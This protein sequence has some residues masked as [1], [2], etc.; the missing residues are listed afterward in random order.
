MNLPY[1]VRLK[2]LDFTID[3]AVIPKF[4][5]KKRSRPR[6]PT[7]PIARAGDKRLRLEA[8]MIW[9]EKSVIES[10]GRTANNHTGA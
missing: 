5:Q 10:H 2:I 8:L 1:Y 3:S 7:P 4:H 6:F 9:I